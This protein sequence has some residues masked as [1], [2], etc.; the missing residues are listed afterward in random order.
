[1]KIQEHKIRAYYEMTVVRVLVIFK[2][3]KDYTRPLAFASSVN[4]K[5]WTYTMALC[6]I[7]GA[8][9]KPG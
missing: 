4:I 9:F 5:P 7:R 6:M 1:M 3:L 8:R 2:S